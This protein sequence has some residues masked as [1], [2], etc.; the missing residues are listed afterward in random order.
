MS[1]KWERRSDKLHKRRYGMRV[2]GRSVFLLQS[3]GS[4]PLRRKGK[5]QPH[6]HPQPGPLDSKGNCPGCATYNLED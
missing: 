2:T 4:R 5:Q 6:S 1:E 3:L